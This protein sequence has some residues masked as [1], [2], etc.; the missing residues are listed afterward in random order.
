VPVEEAATG[1]RP[2]VALRCIEH[3]LH[4]A[5]DIPVGRSQPADFD[6]EPSCDRGA[7]L[8]TVER[9]AF[10]FARFQDFLGQ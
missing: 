7:H 6:P 10:Y 9:F 5:F 2:G 4:H 3:H 1:Q 8:I